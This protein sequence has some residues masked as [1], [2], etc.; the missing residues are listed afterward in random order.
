MKKIFLLTFLVC[1]VF[2]LVGCSSDEAEQYVVSPMIKF[3]GKVYQDVGG[4][5]TELPSDDYVREKI[6]Y[7]IPQTKIPDKDLTTNFGKVGD[8]FYYSPQDLSAIYFVVKDEEGNF[9]H[10]CK[11]QLQSEIQYELGSDDD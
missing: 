10:Y 5:L 3:D 6:L 7:K 2:L 4:R 11:F 8:E 9:K 1:S